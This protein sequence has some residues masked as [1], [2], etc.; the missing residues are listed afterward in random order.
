M[1]QTI[2]RTPA[3]SPIR[4]P[5]WI[6]LYTATL[7][8]L[9]ALALVEVVQPAHP[10]RVG[11]RCLL[12]LGLFATMAV[13]LRVNRPALDLENWCDCAGQRMTIRVIESRGPK[14]PASEPAVSPQPAIELEYELV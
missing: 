5:R 6:L 1:C 9:A 2:S 7:A 10:V 11:L 4:G 13:W 8:Q 3:G 12:A 14:L